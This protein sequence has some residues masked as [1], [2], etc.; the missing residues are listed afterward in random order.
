VIPILG[1]PNRVTPE[2]LAKA[3]AD[4]GPR[5]SGLP[6][7]QVA[8]LIGGTSR[9]H[10]LTPAR[11]REIGEQLAALAAR[12]GVGLL[13]TTSRRTGAEQTEALKSSL[14]PLVEAGKALL[15]SSERDGENPYLGF[16]AHADHILATEDSANMLTEAAVTGK[17][18]HLLRLEGGNAKFDRLRETLQ[19]RGIVRPFE[20]HLPHWHYEALQET[21]RA[22]DAIR[23]RL[24]E[25]DALRPTQRSTP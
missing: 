10:R 14:A 3:R 16:L 20:G 17:P 15:W 22:A 23:L 2:K 11:A 12:D 7:P 18:I 25:R 24:A 13:V 9:A 1:A 21:R 5:F 4:W 6:T 8:A 19:Y